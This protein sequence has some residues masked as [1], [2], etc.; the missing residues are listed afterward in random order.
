MYILLHDHSRLA[1]WLWSLFHKCMVCLWREWHAYEENGILDNPWLMYLHCSFYYPMWKFLSVSCDILA[2]TNFFDV[3]GHR[4]QC[5]FVYFD[6]T[7]EYFGHSC[8]FC[9]N[10]IDHVFHIQYHST[11]LICILSFMHAAFKNSLTTFSF[12]VRHLLHSWTFFRGTLAHSLM[13]V[14]TLL[15]FNS[16]YEWSTSLYFFGPEVICTSISLYT[17][18]PLLH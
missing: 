17:Y 3:Y 2:P 6:G 4:V 7:A 16:F 12:R 13:T 15:P 18:S 1:T 8:L 11:A 9:S 10:C 14:T 5:L